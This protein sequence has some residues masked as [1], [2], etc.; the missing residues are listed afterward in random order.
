MAHCNTTLVHDPS[1]KTNRAT[2]DQPHLGV[3]RQG[4]PG[5][6][7]GELSAFDAVIPPLTPANVVAEDPQEAYLLMSNRSSSLGHGF[8]AFPFGWTSSPYPGMSKTEYDFVRRRD[9]PYSAFVEP[10]VYTSNILWGTHSS[11]HGPWVVPGVTPASQSKFVKQT[12]IDQAALLS[13]S[14]SF[15]RS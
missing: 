1:V 9:R 6:F 11:K 12:M 2:Y 14:C 8:R 5:M 3:L 10:N 13:P 4:P 15:S 7:D